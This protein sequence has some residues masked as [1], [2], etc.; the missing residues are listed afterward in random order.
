MKWLIPILLVLTINEYFARRA[1]LRKNN[2]IGAFFHLVAMVF[3]F[4]ALTLVI[5][6]VYTGEV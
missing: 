4:I 1:K 5:Y 3:L 2:N 6:F